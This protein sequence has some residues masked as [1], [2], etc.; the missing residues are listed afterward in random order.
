MTISIEDLMEVVI[1]QLHFI[2]FGSMIRA[3]PQ[4]INLY[5]DF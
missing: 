2:I 1:I 3:K 5:I 4:K